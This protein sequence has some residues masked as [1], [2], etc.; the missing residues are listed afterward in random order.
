[1]KCIIA[2]SNLRV[3][4]DSFYKYCILWM[5]LKLKNGTER[6][7]RIGAFNQSTRSTLFLRCLRRDCPL[8]ALKFCLFIGHCFILRFL[9]VRLKKSSRNEFTVLEG[10]LA[11]WNFT[12]DAI[13]PLR[14]VKLVNT[15]SLPMYFSSHITNSSLIHTISRVQLS[16][17][18]N[19]NIYTMFICDLCK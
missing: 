15:C 3:S 9:H 8:N 11:R 19:F 5:H 13:L 7:P 4:V 6:Q 17:K 12:C 2:F 1:M 10:V 18:E 14:D 16:C